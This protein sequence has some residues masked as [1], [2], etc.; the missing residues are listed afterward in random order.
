[1]SNSQEMKKLAFIRHLKTNYHTWVTEK[2]V[3]K[4]NDILTTM[5]SRIKDYEQALTR[6]PKTEVAK[7]QQ[8]IDALNKEKGWL[9]ARKEKAL[10]RGIMRVNQLQAQPH[11]WHERLFGLRRRYGLDAMERLSFLKNP[12]PVLPPPS[13]WYKHPAVIVG[14][15]LV[16]GALLTKALLSGRNK[17]DA[18]NT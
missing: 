18:T 9:T 7:I 11:G 10:E 13:A 4:I 16:G 8:G 17:A 1:M 12:T 3:S 14:G 2:E 5:D 6:V 15:A